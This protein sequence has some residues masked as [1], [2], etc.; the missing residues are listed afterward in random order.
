[1]ILQVAIVLYSSALASERLPEPPENV[2][3]R[4]HFLH[5][6]GEYSQSISA[7]NQ[8]I[9]EEDLTSEQKACAILNRARNYFAMSQMDKAE[10]DT[11]SA[12]RDDPGLHTPESASVCLRSSAEDAAALLEI[13]AEAP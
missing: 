4:A 5:S 6:E 7:L 10:G 13:T 12:L 9:T 11:R 3:D 1:M 2:C 8:C